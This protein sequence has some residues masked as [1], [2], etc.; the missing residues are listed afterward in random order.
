MFA[1]EQA[2]KKELAL[3]EEASY[4]HWLDRQGNPECETSRNVEAPGE[5]QR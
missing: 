5:E 3:E 4:F 1:S 2:A